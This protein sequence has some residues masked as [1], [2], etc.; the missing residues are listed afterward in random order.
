M[1]NLLLVVSEGS[2][3]GIIMGE[4]VGLDVKLI[5]FKEGSVVGFKERS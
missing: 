1:N 2:S 4:K 5:G 3:V